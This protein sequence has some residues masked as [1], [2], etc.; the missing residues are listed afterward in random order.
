[1]ARR[2]VEAEK[3][4]AVRPSAAPLQAAATLSFL[5]ETRGLLNWTL[6]D[7]QKSLLIST[8]AGREVISA[9][10]LQG[11]AKRTE[12]SQEWLTTIDGETVSGSKAPRF[13]REA[14]GKSLEALRERIKFINKDARSPYRIAEAVAFGDFLH[15]AAQ[16]Q[17]ADVGIQF[18]SRD[19]AHG[20]SAQ[21]NKNRRTVKSAAAFLKD[22]R[23]RDL[24]IS[25]LAYRPW[26][27][28][29]SHLNLLASPKAKNQVA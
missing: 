21:K 16:A 2:A 19:S 6:R 15:G 20:A 8:S 25:L 12:N 23:G 1:M 5:K 17:A 18:E 13:T 11:Y 9:L 28:E 7:V 29:R 10:E 14:V 3:S 22:L 26:M 24:K 27:S 4:H